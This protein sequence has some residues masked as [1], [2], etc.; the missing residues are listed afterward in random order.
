MTLDEK[1]ALAADGQDGV[2]RLGIPA[3]NASDGPNGVRSGGPGKTAFPN[4]QVVAATWDPALAERF[5]DALGAETAGKGSTSCSAPTVNI[6]RTPYFGR[7]AETFGEDPYLS[8]QIAAAE[9]RGMQRQQV[10]AAGQALRSEQPGDRR[11]GNPWVPAALAPP[12]TCVVSE[13]ALQ[14]IYFPA[15]KAAVQ[16]GGA[17]VGDVLLSPHQRHSTRVRTPSSWAR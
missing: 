4:A 15:F 9:I 6:L 12:S 3:L 1:I 17:G 2:P 7:A 13:R 10:I 16:Q 14:E 5:G 11:F 8:G